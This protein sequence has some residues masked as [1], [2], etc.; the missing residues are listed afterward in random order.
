M[1]PNLESDWL[2]LDGPQ[3]IPR[4]DSDLRHRRRA[5]HQP[6]E[7]PWP[8][9]GGGR[10]RLRQSGAPQPHTVNCDTRRELRFPA[11]D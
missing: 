8:R 10:F 1:A 6:R 5:S 7:A 9:Q 2:N 11:D 4:A 3:P